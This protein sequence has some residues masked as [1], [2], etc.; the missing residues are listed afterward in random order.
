MVEVSDRP[1]VIIAV[2]VIAILVIGEVIVYTSDSSDYG[3]E[4]SLEDGT[5]H[6]DLDSRGSKVFDLV[7]SDNGG[8]SGVQKLY[9]Y[10]DPSYASKYGVDEADVGATPNDQENHLRQLTSLLSYRGVTDVTFLDATQLRDMMAECVSSGRCSGTGVVVA[11]GALPDTVYTGNEDDLVLEWISMGGTMYWAGGLVG[12]YYATHDAVYQVSGYQELFFGAEC[13]NTGDTTKAY[14]E[15][16][17]NGYRSALSLSNNDVTYAVSLDRL[18]EGTPALG[19]GY[20][21]D[22]YQSIALVGHGSGSMVVFGG[23]LSNFQRYDMA[24]VI[25]SGIGPSSEIVDHIHGTVSGSTSGTADA[26]DGDV[27]AYV[28]LG[29]YFPVYGK[30]IR[31]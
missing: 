7:V 30:G 19:I 8:Y 26:G 9:M 24:Q 5:I 23:Q 18:P 13:L 10:L 20:E 29:G 17:S 11:S 15:I 4:M 31:F 25:A 28:Y 22:G 21:E 6:Y 16:T 1:I 2:A 12:A 3:A 27:T 14:S